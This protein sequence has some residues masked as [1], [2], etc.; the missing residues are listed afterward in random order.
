MY[1]R[2]A[3]DTFAFSVTKIILFIASFMK[4]FFCY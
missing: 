3:E 4:R 2:Y 1:L